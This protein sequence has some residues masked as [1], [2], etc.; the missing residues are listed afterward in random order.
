MSSAVKKKILTWQE[1]NV[2]LI[3]QIY[4]FIKRLGGYELIDKYIFLNATKK[5]VIYIKLPPEIV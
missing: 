4:V 5:N 1:V 2:T 3:Q